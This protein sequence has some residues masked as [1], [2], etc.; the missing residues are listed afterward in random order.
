MDQ[1]IQKINYV[2][3][4]CYIL[5]PLMLISLGILLGYYLFYD[6]GAGAVICFMGFPLIAFLWWVFGGKLIYKQHCK[7]LVRELDERGFS[8]NQTF[9][10]RGATVVVDLNRGELA[11]VFFWNPFTHYILPAKRIERTW[12]DDGAGGAGFM[13]G[14]SRVSFLFQVDGVKVRVD[15]FT[16]NKRW[17][18]DSDYIL[19]GISKADVMVE[20]LEQAKER[21]K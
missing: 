12:V 3:L 9:D 11:I 21:S 13:R 16:S 14:S 2:Y 20:A 5:V 6:G 19:T 18:M 1:K 17:R 10:G 8:R 7:K 15:T 4:L